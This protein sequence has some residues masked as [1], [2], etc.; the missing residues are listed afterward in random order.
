[1]I[2]ET[3]SYILRW[4]SRCRWRLLC[5]SYCCNDRTWTSARGNKWY[6]I[7]LARGCVCG[8]QT[9]R[10]RWA[11]ACNSHTKP[12]YDTAFLQ[13][14]LFLV[15]LFFLWKRGSSGPVTQWR[16]L[17]SCDWL[18]HSHGSL[19]QSRLDLKINQSMKTPW[20]ECS[21]VAFSY[22]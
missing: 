20:Q 9:T 2:S 1:M 10:S 14:D 21:G 7:V 5:S 22:S 19:I 4:R 15:H 16:Q 3:Q 12:I 6:G 18:W 11:G 13:I 17:V 8:Y